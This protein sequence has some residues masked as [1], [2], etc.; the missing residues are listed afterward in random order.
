M[1]SDH[2]VG[3]DPETFSGLTGRSVLRKVLRRGSKNWKKGKDPHPQDKIQH[4]DFTKDRQPLYYKTPACAFYL[5]Q[6]Q[7]LQNGGFYEIV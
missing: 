3:V 1:V 2:G 5:I 7:C 6:S 4:L